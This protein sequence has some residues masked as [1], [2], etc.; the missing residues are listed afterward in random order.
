MHVGSFDKFTGEVE[1]DE[2]LIGGAAAN[3]HPSRK[4][5]AGIKGGGSSGKE[6]VHAV[7][8][9]S[10]KQSKKISRV[11]ASVIPDMKHRTI[12]PII[13]KMVKPGS[14]LYTDT[15]AAYTSPIFS[16]TFVHEMIDHAKAYVEGRVHTNGLENFW[17]L[18]K[19]TIGGT[20]VSVD[21]PHLG[22]YVDEQTF[23]FNER[24]TTDAGRFALI[25]PGVVGK[26]LTY[27]ELIGDDTADNLKKGGAD[28]SGLAN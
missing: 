1:S 28:G 20:Y 26:R 6:I 8:Q 23:R 18:L 17:S 3:M 10:D 4:L 12:A 7:L 9:R 24:G 16:E 15:M 5:R 2:T 21:A 11:I 19:R 27:K 14:N 25:M 13:H 22:R